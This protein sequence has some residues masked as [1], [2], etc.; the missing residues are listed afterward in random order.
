VPVHLRVL[1]EQHDWRSEEL[2]YWFESRQDVIFLGRGL[3]TR[4]LSRVR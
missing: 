2:V 3:A 4:L 1:M